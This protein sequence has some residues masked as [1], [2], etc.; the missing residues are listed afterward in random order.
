MRLA[1]IREGDI[2]EVND[3]LPYLACARGR[4]RRR[5]LVEPVNGKFSPAPVRGAD[6]VAHWRQAR[7]RSAPTHVNAHL[8]WNAT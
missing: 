1:N 3:G 5:L 4:R 7:T 8:A 2:V 6:V